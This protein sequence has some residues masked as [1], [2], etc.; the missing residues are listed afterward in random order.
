MMSE[1]GGVGFPH[2]VHGGSAAAKPAS[3]PAD[4]MLADAITSCKRGTP[5]TFRWNAYLVAG[6]PQVL[7]VCGRDI[8][9]EKTRALRDEG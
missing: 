9:P 8:G 1:P 6:R 3:S 2:V 5:G 7:G 4:G